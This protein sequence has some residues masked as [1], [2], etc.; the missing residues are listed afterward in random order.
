[1]LLL[2]GFHDAGFV[3]LVFTGVMSCAAIAVYCTDLLLFRAFV[4]VLIVP[5][6]VACFIQG[7]RTD[8]WLAT[9]MAVIYLPYL[10]VEGNRSHHEYW[11]GITANKLLEIRAAE[12]E[13][14]RQ[15]AEAANEAKSSFLATVSH[16]IRTPMNAIIGM[17][18]LLIDSELDDS[19][20]EYAE[21][22]RS[23]GAGMLQLINDIL[24]YSKIE[25]GKLELECVSFNPLIEVNETVEMMA[26][27]AEAK[28]LEITSMVSGTVPERAVGD[29]GRWPT[30][31]RCSAPWR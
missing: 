13:E 29:P 27:E 3:A 31:A 21:I 6:I 25:A 12:L 11:Q 19:Q 18:G 5:Q 16:E 17:T 20:R 22:V 8:V 4:F 7:G 30:A 9:S 10:W 28:G 23:S 26:V 14:A 15:L 1:V 24:D 2:Y